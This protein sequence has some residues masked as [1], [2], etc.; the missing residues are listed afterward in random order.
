MQKYPG[1]MD[2]IEERGN[3]EEKVHRGKAGCI[4]V[5]SLVFLGAGPRVHEGNICLSIYHGLWAIFAGAFAI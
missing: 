1:N 5:D 2:H 4:C 3:W